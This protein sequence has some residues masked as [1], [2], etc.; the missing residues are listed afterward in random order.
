MTA[1]RNPTADPAPASQ[2]VPEKLATLVHYLR[3][4]KVILDSDLAELYGVTTGRLNEAVQRNLERFPA[5]FMFQLTENEMNTLLSQTA[6]AK[7]A[8]SLS[9]SQSVTSKRGGRR[10]RP[11]AFTEQG[12]A[13]L[14][15]NPTATSPLAR[16]WIM[17]RGRF[18]GGTRGSRKANR[19]PL[20]APRSS[21]S[22][23]PHF[24][25]LQNVPLRGLRPATIHFSG[26]AILYLLTV[27]GL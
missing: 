26:I 17:R 9:R 12:V 5:D 2:L 15:S 11:Y 25:R 7:N 10:T 21:L 16:G 20:I 4:E 24:Y 3:R 1:K 13:M 8:E 18:R 14:S 27:S 22:L 19:S 23:R 6:I